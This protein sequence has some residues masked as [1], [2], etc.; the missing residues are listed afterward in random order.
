MTE[1]AE[2]IY[3]VARIITW[4]PPG[5]IEQRLAAL[6]PRLNQP[7]FRV[8][9]V[10][11]RERG[12]LADSLEQ[13][14]VPVVVF[15]MKSRLEPAGLRA[16]AQWMRDQQVDLV[17]SHMYRSNVP[18]TI[19][20]RMAGVRAVLCQMHNI[21]TWETWR[22]RWM[23]R[24]LMRW[25]TA[26][27]AVSEEVKRDIVAN[28]A[29]DPERV[30]VLYN[31]IDLEKYS[32]AQRDPELAERLG[33]PKGS[34]VVVVLARLAQQKGHIRLLK[35]LDL[36]R[37]E[38]PPTHVLLVGEGKMRDAIQQE[39]IKR[40]LQ[41]MVTFAGHR[42]DVP[43]VLALADLSV[44][45]SDR[46][47]FSNAIVE[48]LA[49]GVPVVAT[50]VGGNSE[51]IVNGES[52]LLVPHDDV[53]ALARALKLLLTDDSL[54]ERTSQAARRRAQR[55]SLDQMLEETRRLY[56]RVLHFE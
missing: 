27:V 20:A 40:H 6:L 22:Q 30:H 39:V 25:R 8:T 24:L 3:H 21:N 50:D 48:S 36:V 1:P 13:A 44:L 28:L 5:G 35:A 10:C 45:A 18:A 51:A 43:Q 12:L 14:G 55:F 56:R 37:D 46:E 31:G 15:P 52:G 42:D 2:R 38:L 34:R 11:L 4:L 19:A 49:A 53:H 23:D 26:M 47:G 32:A 29:C 17:H 16:L 7:P 33:V 54:R 41:E 9:V